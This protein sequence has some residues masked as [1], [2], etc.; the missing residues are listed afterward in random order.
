M[1]YV[2]SYFLEPQYIPY[3]QAFLQHSHKICAKLEL[4][5]IGAEACDKGNPRIPR[6]EL[7]DLTVIGVSGGM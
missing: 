6:Y 7:T 5:F 1:Y 3:N 4:A 2:M